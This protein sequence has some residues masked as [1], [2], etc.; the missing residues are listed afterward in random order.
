MSAL[1]IRD[2]VILSGVAC[3]QAGL[4][5]NTEMVSQDAFRYNPQ[6]AC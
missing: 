4:A 6:Q 1:G 3:G 5:F 2:M